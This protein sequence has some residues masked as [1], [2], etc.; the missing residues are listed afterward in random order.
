LGGIS[1]PHVL[2][3]DAIGL[4]SRNA[5][6]PWFTLLVMVARFIHTQPMISIVGVEEYASVV[7]VSRAK[8]TGHHKKT[9]LIRA[10]IFTPY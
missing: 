8:R 10:P 9:V 1:C 6:H 2:Q 7:P 3:R 4:L 5:S